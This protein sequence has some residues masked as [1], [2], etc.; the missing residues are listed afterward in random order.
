A[1]PVPVTAAPIECEKALKPARFYCIA[2]S[3]SNDAAATAL[4]SIETS[5]RQPGRFARGQLRCRRGQSVVHCWRRGFLGGSLQRRD[6]IPEQSL[7]QKSRGHG[8]SRPALRPNG[9]LPENGRLRQPGT[10]K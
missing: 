5:K 7:S 8:Q 2:C 3:A 1:L 6:A 4:K 9:E 10:A